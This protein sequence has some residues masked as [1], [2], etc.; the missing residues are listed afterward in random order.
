MRSVGC[1]DPAVITVG[2]REPSLVFLV[3]TDLAMGYDGV[4]AA[5]FLREPGCRVAL[6]EQRVSQG[7]AEGIAGLTPAPRL[8]TTIQGFNLNGGKRLSISVYVRD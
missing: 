6:I 3:G 2:Y 1:T 4:A 5:A 7:F 8:A